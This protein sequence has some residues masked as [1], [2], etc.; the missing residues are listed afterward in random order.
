MA[1]RGRRASPMRAASGCLSP[2]VRIIPQ[3]VPGLQPRIGACCQ[4]RAIYYQ[5][6]PTMRRIVLRR[7]SARTPRSGLRLRL[8][9]RGTLAEPFGRRRIVGHEPGFRRT[10]IFTNR[11][12]RLCEGIRNKPHSCSFVSGEAPHSCPEASA[13]SRRLKRR[14]EARRRSFGLSSLLQAIVL[15]LDLQA[16]R[17]RGVSRGEAVSQTRRGS[18]SRVSASGREQGRGSPRSLRLRV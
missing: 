8:A 1:H 7:Y 3:Y 4:S 5:Q 2:A 18:W 9:S 10:R 13:T 15:T 12:S 16:V 17:R 11:S 14:G 6:K